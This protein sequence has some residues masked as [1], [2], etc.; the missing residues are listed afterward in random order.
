MSNRWVIEHL[1]DLR[2]EVLECFCKPEAC[3][4]DYLVVLVDQPADE[5]FEGIL[6]RDES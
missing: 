1:S 2:D 5:Y 6:N 4:G 3:H